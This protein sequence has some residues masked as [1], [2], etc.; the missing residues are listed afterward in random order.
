MDQ[1]T[2]QLRGDDYWTSPKKAAHRVSPWKGM[3][4]KLRERERER[5]REMERLAHRE[6]D[7]NEKGCWD[8]VTNEYKKFFSDIEA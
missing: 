5:E 3:K 1:C 6:T 8:D 4:R 7:R 2:V